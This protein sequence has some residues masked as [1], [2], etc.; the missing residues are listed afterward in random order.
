MQIYIYSDIYDLILAFLSHLK[1]NSAEPD[2]KIAYL[3]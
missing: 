3:E 2:S 1:V